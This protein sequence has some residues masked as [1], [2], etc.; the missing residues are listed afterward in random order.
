MKRGLELYEG[1]KYEESKAKIGR[2]DNDDY[3]HMEG[4]QESNNESEIIEVVR[5]DDTAYLII[6]EYLKLPQLEEHT[7]ITAWREEADKSGNKCL[8]IFMTKMDDSSRFDSDY[9]SNKMDGGD[10]IG[11]TSARLSLLKWLKTTYWD[12]GFTHGDLTMN[13]ILYNEDN[14]KIYLVDLF[15][16]LDKHNTLT[17]KYVFN[18]SLDLYDILD[19]L[20]RNKDENDFTKLGIKDAEKKGGA[21]EHFKTLYEHVK[22]LEPK[23]HDLDD[24]T[25]ETF[26]LNYWKENKVDI[27]QVV[28]Y[29]FEKILELY[30]SDQQNLG[31]KDTDGSGG[32][33][34]SKKR[35]QKKGKSIKRKQKKG[36][37]IKRKQKKGKHTKRKQKK[38]KSIK[39]KEEKRK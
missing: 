20:T 3:L 32:F 11:T 36:K 25:F 14:G 34:L 10:T 21:V 2:G 28:K 27:I 16:N 13:N 6:S 5:S 33:K 26:L 4:C 29:W 19:N 12:N 7:A 1:S 37:S 39:R 9:N 17:Y 8:K 23:S 38:G 35:K 24:D 18:V 31:K 15:D 30:E 22:E